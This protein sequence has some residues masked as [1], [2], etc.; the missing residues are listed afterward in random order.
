MHVISS[1][2]YQVVMG[3]VSEIRLSKI[4]VFENRFWILIFNASFQYGTW[5]NH[6]MKENL[7]QFMYYNPFLGLFSGTTLKL[8][9]PKP[10]FLGTRLIINQAQL[11]RNLRYCPDTHQYP[12]KLELTQ[13]EVV[14][15]F[16]PADAGDF[17][18]ATVL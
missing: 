2:P 1:A 15:D 8:M 10:K 5:T 6:L 12:R 16:V 11:V 7:V 14:A 17:E 3:Q 13:T 18:P 9:Y 4:R